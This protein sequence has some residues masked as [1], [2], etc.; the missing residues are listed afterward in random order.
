MAD[1]ATLGR[2]VDAVPHRPRPAPRRDRAA[3]GCR[4]P[5]PLLRP[6][7]RRGRGRIRCCRRRRATGRPAGRPGALPPSVIISC[8][9]YVIDGTDLPQAPPD[10]SLRTSREPVPPGLVAARPDP[11]WE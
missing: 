1:H 9:S 4:R 8:L 10:V 3:L 5:G 11:E 6:A 7:A 2:D